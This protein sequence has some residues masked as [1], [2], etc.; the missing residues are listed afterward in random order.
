MIIRQK[1]AHICETKINMILAHII[2][3][4][5][6]MIPSARKSSPGAVSKFF[7]LGELRHGSVAIFRAKW[8]FASL[9]RLDELISSKFGTNIEV[10]NIKQTKS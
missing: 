4:F 1:G 9:I 5:Y 3:L 10:V 8:Y 2:I 7:H 6:Q